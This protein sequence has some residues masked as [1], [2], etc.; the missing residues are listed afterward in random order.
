MGI[1]CLMEYILPQIKAK[2]MLDL[3][4]LHT[5]LEMLALEKS[6]GFKRS[7]LYYFN[8]IHHKIL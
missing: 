3:L 7:T 1:K 6:D 4:N 2:L 8:S 5:S